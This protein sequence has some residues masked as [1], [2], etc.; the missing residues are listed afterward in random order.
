ML[1][2]WAWIPLRGVSGFCFAGAA[3]IVES[4]LS[5]EAEPSTR[6]RI[7]GFYTMVNLLGT[8]GGQLLLITGDIS[9]ELF[10]GLAAIF[11]SLAL[12]PTAITSSK[13][14]SPLVSVDI[15][16]SAL[17]RN[18]PIAVFAVFM[19]GISN[20]SFGTL[21]PVY[22]DKIGLG[23]TSVVLFTSIPVLAGALTQIPVGALSD[24]FDRRY[25]LLILAVVALAV[26]AGFIIMAPTGANANIFLAAA[27]GCAIFS[28]YPVLIAHA[29]DHAEP[30]SYI[31]TSGGLL[32]VFGVGSIIGPFVG[33]IGFMIIGEM[34]LFFT[35]TVA[36]ALII[37]FGVWRMT[38]RGQID[39]ED[40]TAFQAAP[41]AR[42]AT[43]ETYGLGDHGE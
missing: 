14:P 43:P 2:P 9:T 25:V 22:A 6:G 27:L 23:I 39:P 8:T 42:N 38:R 29:N 28:M 26:D 33:G 12:I 3:M 34:S 35:I 20:G 18:S 15:K 19:V 40:K 5:E 4:W 41:M 13:S 21:A 30:G 24:R 16:L 7:F 36:H 1:S 10:F 11:Y 32:M 31:Q 37:M 17:W